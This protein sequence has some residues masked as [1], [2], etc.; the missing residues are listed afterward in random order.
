LKLYSSHTLNIGDSQLILKQVEGSF[1]VKNEN[2]K[3]YHAKATKLLKRISNYSFEY[4][5]RARNARADALANMAMD[6]RANFSLP[7]DNLQLSNFNK[8]GDYSVDNDDDFKIDVTHVNDDI[9]SHINE[10][11]IISLITILMI[12]KEFV[13]KNKIMKMNGDPIDEA[14]PERGLQSINEGTATTAV[15]LTNDMDKKR[16]SKRKRKSLFQRKKLLKRKIRMM[17]HDPMAWHGCLFNV[18]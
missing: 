11:S 12:H 6:Q 17:Y 15:D 2:L 3:L 5:P 8:D 4:I 1:K 18:Q 13:K 7:I 9:L 10:D 16:P 14:A